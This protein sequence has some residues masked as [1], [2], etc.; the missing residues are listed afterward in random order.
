MLSSA[1]DGRLSGSCNTRK[2]KF[3]KLQ[4]LNETP[5]Q[6]Y[7][8]SL[9]IWDHT[10]L[11]A[12]RHKWIHPALTQARGRYSIYLPQRTEGCVDLG[13]WLVTYQD[14]LPPTYGQPSKSVFNLFSEVEPFAATVI[15]ARTHVL[16]GLLRPERLKLR[17]IVGRGYWG[18]SLWKGGSEPLPTS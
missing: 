4:L 6:S 16:W 17:P 1:N 14:G 2:V 5:S 11:P 18:G 12:T 15:A 13:D 9:A 8:K 7:W 10:V 3:K